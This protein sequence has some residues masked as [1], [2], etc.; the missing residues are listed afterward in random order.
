MT[1]S[2]ATRRKSKA[3]P[4][5]PK[6]PDGC[7]LTPHPTGRW[8]KKILGKLYYFGPWDDLEGALAK[9]EWELED[10]LAGREPRPFGDDIPEGC[11]VAGLVN[12]FLN[13]KRVAMEG[14]ELSPLSFMDYHKN[15]GFVVAHFGKTRRVD[16]LG[17]DD[18][19]QLRETLAKGRSVVTLK[20][21]INR[22]RVLFKFA[23]NQRLI[24][25]DVDYRQ[26]FNKPSAKLMRRAHNARGPRTFTADE[27]RKILAGADPV[28][29]AMVLLGVNAGFGNTDISN[30]PQSAVDL[31]G[32]WVEFPRPKTEIERRIPL[33]V[34][35]ATA[36]RA[37]IRMRPTPIDKA[38]NGLCFLTT[39]GNR[40]TRT[41]VTPQPDG[42]DR[43]VPLDSLTN[44]FKKHLK[45][46]GFS[47]SR[48]FYTMRHTFA[49]VGGEARDPATVESI[50]GHVDSSMA[51]VYRH[52][53]S[54]ERLLAVVNTVRDWL[55]PASE[56]DRTD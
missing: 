31:D 21:E 54:D 13:H 32:G 51:G 19:E 24:D 41:K 18:F 10:R 5:K 15:C 53:V 47:G 14:G 4:I 23:F 42:P 39:Y 1:E 11:D 43:I 38:D 27:L 49:T 30:L 56:S 22:T 55:W 33:W 40:W 16:D 35:T 46:L 9:L 37:A 28:L 44:K 29:Q 7:P 50:L 25:K 36:I 8:C 52:G 12:K 17:P 45:R 48:N 34:E 26:S 20:N 3:K 6:K 2:T